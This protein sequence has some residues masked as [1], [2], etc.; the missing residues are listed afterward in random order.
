MSR[1]RWYLLVNG[2]VAFWLVAASVIVVAHR[3]V[4]SGNW[5]MVHLLLLGAVSTAILIWSQH[6]ADTLLRR[7]APGG[8]A[9][10]GARLLGHTV[11]VGL[12]VAGMIATVWP[13]VLAG[14]IMVGA[15]AVTHGVTLY[16][17][18][19]G[20]LP[21]RFAPLVQY[22]MAA[23]LALAVGVGLGV[24]MARIP[25]PA[26]LH[27]RLYAAHLGFNLLGWVGLTVVGTVILLW[28]T[29]LHTRV[30]DAV[31]STARR[32]LLLMV[33]GLVI[34]AAGSVLDVRY[35][36]A[37]GVF[38]YLVGVGFVAVEGVM[39]ARRSTQWTFASWSIGAAFT[40]FVFCTIAF[41]VVVV[42]APTWAVAASGVAW[43]VGPFAVGFAAQVLL[44]AMSYLL[45]VVLGG[46]PDVSRRT[47][48][49]LNR[50][51]LYRVAVVNMGIIAYLLPVPSFVKV[52]VSLL[53]FVVLSVF[54]VLAV[55]A[56]AASRPAASARAQERKTDAAVSKAGAKVPKADAALP[57]RHGGALAAA[58]A[59]V[60]IAMTVGI[61]LDPVAAGLSTAGQTTVKPTGQTTTV[62]MTMK[63]MRFHPSVVD[64]PAG[65]E[66]V[67]VLTNTD[68][69][70][71]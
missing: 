22:Y 61:A 38:V 7:P 31:D 13:L 2:L 14:G 69:Q 27:E 23:G 58:V 71:H 54:L 32:A 4:P 70:V 34:L 48:R 68:N 29:V 42:T 20:G 16:L 12:V 41:G 6:F 24:T 45:P 3:F 35:I 37:L 65:N 56:V 55:R 43:L 8:R 66:L 60:I 19:K 57:P 52:V 50:A 40:W 64:V 49:E 28:P 33:S 59:T 51:G 17:Q 25:L 62:E 44:G 39:Q 15:V 46:G 36:F 30:S 11:G 47:A 53:V 21:A 9:F 5:L 10:L 18:G 67:I 1:K 26:D 63:D